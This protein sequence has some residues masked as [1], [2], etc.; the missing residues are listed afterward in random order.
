MEQVTCLLLHCKH[1]ALPARLVGCR[2]VCVPPASKALC[3]H[4]SFPAH[5]DPAKCVGGGVGMFDSALA[6]AC[7]E[8]GCSCLG[9]S[10]VES[11]TCFRDCVRIPVE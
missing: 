8:E 3:G 10:K 6:L 7:F 1:V 2:R 5:R 9:R 11:F 4:F